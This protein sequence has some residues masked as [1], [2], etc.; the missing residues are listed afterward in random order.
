[1]RLSGV[2]YFHKI[3]SAGQI[4][5]RYPVGIG[6]GQHT[7]AVYVVDICALRDPVEPERLLRVVGR[8]GRVASGLG[9]G[10]NLVFWL[11]LEVVNTE[12]GVARPH[13]D[14]ELERVAYADTRQVGH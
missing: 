5:Q 14:V 4:G 9:Y 2:T 11:Q 13:P 1:M 7:L 10:S 3:H 12:V 6:Y 8:K